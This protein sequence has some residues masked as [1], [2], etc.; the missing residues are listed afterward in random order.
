MIADAIAAA[1]SDPDVLARL[2]G[3]LGEAARAKAAELRRLPDVARKLERAKLAAIARAVTPA[4]L[5]GIHPTWIEAALVGLPKRAR[6]DLASGGISASGESKD[7]GGGG[8]I[9]TSDRGAGATFDPVGV[10]LARW[11]S[12]SLAPLPVA[13]VTWPR[14]IH[15]VT[16]VSGENLVA[17]LASVGGDQ[18]A[19]ALGAAA[20]RIVDGALDRIARAPRANNLGP[21]RAAIARC[22]IDLSTEAPL[23]IGARAIAPYTDAVIRRQLALRLP[24]TRG[25]AVLFELEAWAREDL[26]ASPTWAALAAQ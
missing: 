11:A 9:S 7:R 6:A 2:G 8:A 14:S 13:D 1:C 19:F 16:R 17:W 21:R 10:W 18:L 20:S 15:D 26:A 24:R 25:L 12:A 23:L 5:R 3:P 22:Q 4:G